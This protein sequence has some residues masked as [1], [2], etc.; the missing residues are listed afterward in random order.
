MHSFGQALD[1]AVVDEI[2]I[3][4]SNAIYYPTS[5]RGVQKNCQTHYG[6]KPVKQVPY[7]SWPQERFKN[8]GKPASILVKEDVG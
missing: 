3:Q 4:R 8:D 2:L 6:T 1:F 7:S 5:L